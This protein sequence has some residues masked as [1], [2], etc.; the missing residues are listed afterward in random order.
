MPR[1]RWSGLPSALRDHL[2]E[3]RRERKITA[4]DPYQ[5]KAWRESN[6]DAPEGLWYK[7]F[8]L[9]KICGHGKTKSAGR[10]CLKARAGLRVVSVVSVRHGRFTDSPSQTARIQSLTVARPVINLMFRIPDRV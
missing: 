5:L 3:R 4:E 2:F 9:F 10:F 6:P 1:I 8:G 7:D